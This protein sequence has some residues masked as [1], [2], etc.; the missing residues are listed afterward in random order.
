M[1]TEKVVK[2]QSGYPFVAIIIT[3]AIT[4][5]VM[6]INNKESAGWAIPLFLILGFL[7]RGLLVIS[8]NSAKILLLFGAYVGSIKK[9]GL[10]WINPFYQRTTISLRARN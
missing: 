7:G 2:P 4:F 5:L 1:Q 8:P 6:V 10:F 3:L 9:S